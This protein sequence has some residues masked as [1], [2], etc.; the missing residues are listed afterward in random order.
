MMT[1]VLLVLAPATAGALNQYEAT[2]MSCARLTA[3]VQKDGKAVVRSL[4]SKVQGLPLVGTYVA[5][6]GNCSTGQMVAKR[7]VRAADTQSC[8][9]LQC[10]PRNRG[11]R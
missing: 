8:R 2:T 6:V 4:S 3:S 10:Q 5:S 7:S 9:L 1:A 11:N